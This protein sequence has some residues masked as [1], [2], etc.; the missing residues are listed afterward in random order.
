MIFLRESEKE[1]ERDEMKKKMN[2]VLI[3]KRKTL[4]ESRRNAEAQEVFRQ[5]LLALTA[6][7]YR[8]ETKLWSA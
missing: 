8:H 3:A 7:L 6:E 1:I 5:G 2:K 4:R